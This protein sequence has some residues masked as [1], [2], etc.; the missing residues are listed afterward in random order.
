VTREDEGASQDTVQKARNLKHG[1]TPRGP[2]TEALKR[3]ENPY[4]PAFDLLLAQLLAHEEVLK[5]VPRIIP[6]N[7]EGATE[8]GA[9]AIAPDLMSDQFDGFVADICEMRN[10]GYIRYFPTFRFSHAM[11]E[12]RLHV[13]QAF[14]RRCYGWI[15]AQSF[16]SFRE[17]AEEIDRT[18]SGKQQEATCPPKDTSMAI[19]P[20]SSH[21]RWPKLK[22]VHRRIREAAPALREYEER[23]SRGV[24]LGSWL[25]TLAGVRH[26]LV[27]REGVIRPEEWRKLKS[28]GRK[29]RFPGSETSDASY[30]LDITPDAANNTI[31]RLREYGLVIYKAVSEVAGYPVTLYD[32]DRGMTIWHR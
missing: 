13:N 17:F 23:N 1:S 5:I 2:G 6:S 31:A 4:Y 14:Q 26:A 28:G 30:V 7:G 29:V 27:H 19:E 32:P 10:D 3:V 15:V 16:E 21:K 20:A 12:A 8:L 24:N 18:I 25:R 9:L 22:E 11:R